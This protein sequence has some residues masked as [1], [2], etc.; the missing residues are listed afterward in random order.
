[1]APVL[2]SLATLRSLA[3]EAYVYGRP[4]VANLTT[5]DGFVREGL[6]PLRARPFN[7]FAHATRLAGAD[8]PFVSVNTDTVYSV[9]QL[10]LSGGPLLLHV[11]DTNGAY[12]VLQ[13]VDA[14]TNN[15]AYVGRRATGTDEA[16]WLIVPPGWAGVV[17][18]EVRGVID[19]PTSL[20]TIVGRTAC[21]GPDDM[22]RV[23]ILHQ[24][25][26]LTPVGS[27]HPGGLPAPDPGADAGLRFF[28]RLRLWTAAFPP[29]APDQAYQ[30]RFQPLGLLEEGPSPYADPDPVVVRALRE[31]LAEG[32]ALVEAAS[33]AEEFGE[34][35]GEA[36]GEAGGDGERPPG[37]WHMDPHLFDY[38][39]D[40]FGVG[41]IDAPRWRAPD[42]EASYLRRAVAA[43]LALWG[44]HGYEAVYA[45]TF[46]DAD[47]EPLTGGRS[48]TLR[49][50]VLPPVA[51]FWSVTMYDAPE[52]H[53]VANPLDR[54]AIGDRTPGLRYADD[55]SLTL[56]IQRD[57]PP[58]PA[59]WLPAP[60]GPFRPVV[61]LYQPEDP[62]I[63]GAY[64]LPRIVRRRAR[65]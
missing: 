43:R 18:R 20:A 32:K 35:F 12:Y 29:S 50:D 57:P 36:G 59:N 56:L 48:Y 62:V 6:G 24:R 55:G 46:R 2:P 15:F 27:P 40:H 47:G 60:P 8:T 33:T 63:D 51:A 41:T 16:S 23:R 17:P 39:L 11:P 3:A 37:A 58:D 49:F 4:L 52:Y 7:R 21:E 34:A 5:V 64:T 1:M 25:L 65:R 19:A 42:R 45:Q 13:F 10:D 9:A 28:E 38:N 31:G 22:E 26:T 61:R 44:N 30:E 53:L 14:W 54:Y